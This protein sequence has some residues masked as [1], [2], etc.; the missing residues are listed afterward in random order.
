MTTAQQTPR[1]SLAFAPPEDGQ[2]AA[3]VEGVPILQLPLEGQPLPTDQSLEIRRAAR[4]EADPDRKQQL[5]QSAAH[6]ESRGLRELEVVD[7]QDGEGA[8]ATL[9]SKVSLYVGQKH[10]LP[11]NVL[12]TPEALQRLRRAGVAVEVWRLY[13]VSLPADANEGDLM[14]GR[15]RL[16]RGGEP[17][18][19]W[20]TTREVGEKEARGLRCQPYETYLAE[21]TTEET[22]DK[23]T[24]ETHP[25]DPYTTWRNAMERWTQTVKT[26]GKAGKSGSTRKIR[27][28]GKTGEADGAGKAEA[29]P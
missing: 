24:M 8:K 4:D 17:Q 5:L 28:T 22:G 11:V 27:K 25:F 19:V 14:L 18:P 23:A 6:L 29:T 15:V 16:Q 20:L 26:S 3:R 2:R 7:A 10:T 9:L 13:A 12:P 1:I 21:K